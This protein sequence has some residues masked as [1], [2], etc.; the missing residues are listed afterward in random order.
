MITENTGSCVHVLIGWLIRQSV[1]ISLTSEN[2][3]CE[4]LTADNAKEE[5]DIVYK[6]KIYLVDTHH[7]ADQGGKYAICM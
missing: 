2:K 1:D 3:K 4:S 6:P 7:L 5:L